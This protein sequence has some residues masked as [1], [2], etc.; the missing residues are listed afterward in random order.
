MW[1][2]TLVISPSCSKPGKNC[3]HSLIVDMLEFNAFSK[4][5]Y[6]ISL[7]KLMTVKLLLLPYSCMLCLKLLCLIPLLRLKNMD[8]LE[9]EYFLLRSCSLAMKCVEGTP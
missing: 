3:S 6:L 2:S 7:S 5:G 4:K 1:I 8:V 9:F